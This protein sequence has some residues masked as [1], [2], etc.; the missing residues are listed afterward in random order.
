VLPVGLRTTYFNR[1]GRLMDYKFITLLNDYNDW[2]D[3]FTGRYVE[4]EDSVTPEPKSFPCYVIDE[5]VG[6]SDLHVEGDLKDQPF[7]A[8]YFLYLKDVEEMVE[9]LS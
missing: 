1:G 3:W 6:Y 7:M 5:I 2:L 8:P 4:T 9:A